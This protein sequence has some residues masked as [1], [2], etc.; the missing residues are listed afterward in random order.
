MT[1]PISG[2]QLIG[3]L[4]PPSMPRRLPSPPPLATLPTTARAKGAGDVSFDVAR[5]DSSGRLSSRELIRALGWPAGQRLNV[6]V[7]DGRIL[8]TPSTTGRHAVTA[9]GE[10]SVP[11]QARALSGIGLD[12]RVLMTADLT[13]GLLMVHPAMS[14]ARLLSGLH[15]DVPGGG[16]VG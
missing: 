8:V 1:R 12:E 14:V 16:C 11:A 9:R 7:V 15:A 10:V 4:I 2:E 5:L 13:G 3:V 6:A